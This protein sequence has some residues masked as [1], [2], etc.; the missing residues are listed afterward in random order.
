MGTELQEV[1]KDKVVNKEEEEKT[2][3]LRI[4][5]GKRPEVTF[6]GFWSGKFIRSAMDSIAKAYR[7]RGRAIRTAP[8]GTR[9]VSTLP[10]LVKKMEVGDV[11]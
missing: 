5:P 2:L 9:D 7:M 11:T 10:E 6:Q 4:L 8:S 1:L 3:T